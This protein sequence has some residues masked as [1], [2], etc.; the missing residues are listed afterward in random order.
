MINAEEIKRM[1]KLMEAVEEEY[2]VLEETEEPETLRETFPPCR[3]GEELNVAD[4][5]VTCNFLFR[6]A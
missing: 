3:R 2:N 4:V 6:D 1:I 5:L